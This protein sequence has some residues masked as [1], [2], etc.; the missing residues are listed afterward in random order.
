MSENKKPRLAEVLGVE[1]GEKFEIE[2]SVRGPFYV[3]SGGLLLDRDG[4]DRP[5]LAISAI[6]HP[7][8]I[9]RRPRWTEQDVRDAKTFRRMWPDKEIE[10]ERAED[11]LCCLTIIQGNLHGYLRLSKVD[12]LPSVK[13]GQTVKLDDIIGGNE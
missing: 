11:N 7:E 12:L 4:T 10:F 6:N 9:K 13:P 3:N 8:I 1:V 5:A 2:T